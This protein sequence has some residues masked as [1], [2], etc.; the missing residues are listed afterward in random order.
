MFINIIFYLF[1]S[2]QIWNLVEQVALLFSYCF[3]LS[4][5]FIAVFQ[6]RKYL[7]LPYVVKG[8]DVSFSG[9]LSFLEEKVNVSELVS[10]S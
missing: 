5:L 2:V 3:K 10:C 4:K 7:P 9:I 8:M 1:L 6:G